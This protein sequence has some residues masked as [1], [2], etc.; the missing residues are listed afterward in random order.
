MINFGILPLT[1]A[2]PDD[3]HKIAPEHVLRLPNVREAIQR[4]NQVYIL[5]Q[6]TSETYL[7]EHGMTDRQVHMLLAGSL[8]N[9][10][11]CASSGD[12][13]HTPAWRPHD[14]DGARSH[15]LRGAGTLSQP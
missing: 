7:A 5:N 10:F 4:G 2:N 14:G 11:A 6:S 8:I 1:F 12:T 3:W 13:A 9:L 15:Y